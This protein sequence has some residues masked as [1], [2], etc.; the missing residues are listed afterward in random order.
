MILSEPSLTSGDF[1]AIS[2]V[3]KAFLPIAQPLMNRD[4]KG[5]V[6]KAPVESP[7][8]KPVMLEST[9]A[10]LALSVNARAVGRIDVVFEY[11]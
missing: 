9:V 4:L 11:S 2:R 5:V 3:C 6:A 10:R 7:S 8:A 1:A